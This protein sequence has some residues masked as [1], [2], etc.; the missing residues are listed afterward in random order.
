VI[1]IDAAQMQSFAGNV[2]EVAT[3]RD[4]PILVMS[5]RAA[6]AY[7]ARQLS[8]LREHCD[9][10]AVS[11][12]TIESVGGGGARCMLAEIFLPRVADKRGEEPPD[13]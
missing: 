1:E 5:S 12:D 9:I 7:T 3:G 10:E 13:E 8:L 6:G 11:L 4:R 2:L